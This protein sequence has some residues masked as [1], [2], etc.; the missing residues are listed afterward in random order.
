M[1]EAEA[2]AVVVGGAA[3]ARAPS[4]GAEE[5]VCNGCTGG[6]AAA[7]AGVEAGFVMK[8]CLWSFWSS[9]SFAVRGA[10][11]EDFVLFS[12]R[13]KLLFLFR[14]ELNDGLQYCRRLSSQ[15]DVLLWCLSP[16]SDVNNEIAFISRF[17]FA[18]ALTLFYDAPIYL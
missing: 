18:I 14:R 16:R 1:A 15:F 6:A 13:T 5:A 9:M 10:E 8:G 7:G 17:D 2:A 3:A 11:A 4:T 12:F